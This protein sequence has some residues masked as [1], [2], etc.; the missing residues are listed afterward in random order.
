MSNGILTTGS[1]TITLG[2]NATISEGSSSYVVG[3]VQTTR[4]LT[5]ENETFGGLGIELQ[6]TAE[7]GATTVTRVTGT[8]I[9]QG[10]VQSI[11]RYFHISPEINAGLGATLVFHYLDDELNSI[12][13]DDLA[14]F[15]SSDFV[16]WGLCGGTVDADANTV[17]LT[18]IDSFSYWT[19][20]DKKN[21]LAVVLANFSALASDQ[22][23]IL[24]WRTE[25]EDGSYQWIIERSESEHGPF[26]EMGRLAAA[27]QSQSPRDYSWSDNTAREGIT[28]YYRIGELGLDG[29][30]TYF[31]PVSCMLGRGRPE[32]N[33]VLGALP[34]PFQNRT[35]IRYQLAH[36]SLVSV[37][38]YNVS[39]QLVRRMDQGWQLPGYY[40]VRWDGTDG[41]GQKLSA[42]V[43]LY[44][45]SLGG[46]Q[47]L[48]KVQLV[49]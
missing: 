31:G 33:L 49:R 38:V 10:S 32:A 45:V 4:T 14:L 6:A 11:K 5:T 46:R 30:T 18:G 44:R 35:E 3:N 21:P 8:P 48:G 27:G 25:S 2:L 37:S 22:S 39:G 9:V 42:G 12:A 43:Y 47:F 24:S 7:P 26:V 17:T 13:E 23:I 20:G 1:D 36:S 16:R 41:N 29:R 34:N 40:Q 15:R 19:L 28:Y